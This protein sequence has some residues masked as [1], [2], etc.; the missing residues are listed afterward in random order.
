MK[1]AVVTRW[2]KVLHKSHS[3]ESGQ[4][5][6]A[7]RQGRSRLHPLHNAHMAGSIVTEK[8]SVHQKW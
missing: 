1:M 7:T 2:T 6:R 8:T 3:L 4:E 5:M